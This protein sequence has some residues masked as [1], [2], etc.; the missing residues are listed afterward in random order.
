MSKIIFIGA[1]SGFGAISFTDI[2]SFA[3]L[4]DSEVVLVDINPKHLSPVEAYARKVVEHYQAP[5]SV[6]CA[7]DWRG[8]GSS[9]R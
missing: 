5:T 3:E 6:A 1:G 4:H 7:S 9:R 2:M 8:M